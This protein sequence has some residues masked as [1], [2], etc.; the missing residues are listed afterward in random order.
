MSSPSAITSPSMVSL[1]LHNFAAKKKDALGIFC[2]ILLGYKKSRAKFLVLL[3]E[4]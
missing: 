2:Q 4:M 3:E 1:S